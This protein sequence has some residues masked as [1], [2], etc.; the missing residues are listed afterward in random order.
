MKSS[1]EY[2]LNKL[3]WKYGTH[4]TLGTIVCPQCQRV[5]HKSQMIDNEIIHLCPICEQNNQKIQRLWL[6][7]ILTIILMIFLLFIK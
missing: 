2:V 6:G 3:T 1:G 7:W 5:W 4:P